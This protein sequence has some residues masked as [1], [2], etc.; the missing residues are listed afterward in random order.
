LAE[1]RQRDQHQAGRHKKGF[2][3]S[4]LLSVGSRCRLVT[5]DA[6]ANHD[7]KTPVLVP[8]AAGKKIAVSALS[9]CKTFPQTTAPVAIVLVVPSRGQPFA[10]ALAQP[11]MVSQE[12]SEFIATIHTLIQRVHEFIAP[13]PALLDQVQEHVTAVAALLNPTPH[14]IAQAAIGFATAPIVILGSRRGSRCEK[15]DG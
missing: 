5:A 3:H 8:E 2:L 4:L 1:G 10:Q 11:W 14:E 12:L 15:E 6:P 9:L 7:Q 13:V